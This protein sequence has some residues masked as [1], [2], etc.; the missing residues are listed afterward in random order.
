M[1]NYLCDLVCAVSRFSFHLQCNNTTVYP[2]G[3]PH[4]YD[5]KGR[6]IVLSLVLQYLIDYLILLAGNELNDRY[7][8]DILFNI[9]I[10]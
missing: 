9:H 3:A 8:Y 1:S 6:Y 4:P 5:G 2:E 7:C 10:G